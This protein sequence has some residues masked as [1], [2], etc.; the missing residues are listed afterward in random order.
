LYWI[1]N[2]LNGLFM[3]NVDSEKFIKELID[4]KILYNPLNFKNELSEKSLL[5]LDE[6]NRNKEWIEQIENVE[7]ILMKTDHSFSDKR[8][9][10]IEKVI[11]WINN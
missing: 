1:K 7:Y 6:N 2:Y 11:E 4:N 9:E 10:L 8:L 5:V 3:L